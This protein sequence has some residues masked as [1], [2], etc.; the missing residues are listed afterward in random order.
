MADTNLG[1]VVAIVSVVASAATA[2][3]STWDKGRTELALEEIKAK[4]EV[5]KSLREHAWTG[6]KERC[7]LTVETARNLAQAYGKVY[8]ELDL[9]KRAEIEANLWAAATMLSTAN[10]KIFLDAYQKGPAQGDN[11]KNAFTDNLVSIAL[12]GL[13]I[14]GQQCLTNP[15]EQ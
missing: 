12:Q 5:Q 14:D 2:I 4:Y 6:R 3:Y 7:S 8:R 9:N 15:A 11:Y 13:A 1:H 10:Q